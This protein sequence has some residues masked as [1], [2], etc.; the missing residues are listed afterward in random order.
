MSQNDVFIDHR[1]GRPVILT[2]RD[3][4]EMR[5]FRETGMSIRD[6]A[7]Y[8]NVSKATALRALAS[9]RKK[10]GP[11]KLPR[12]QRSRAPGRVC[13]TYTPPIAILNRWLR[14]SRFAE[15]PEVQP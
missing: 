10:F 2:P 8:F 11:E 14:S 13:D 7:S 1:L 15:A 9:M 6:C 5:Q 3:K 12:Q 4:F